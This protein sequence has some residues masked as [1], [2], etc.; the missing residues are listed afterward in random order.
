MIVPGLCS[1]TLRQCSPKEIIEVCRA[2]GLQ[3]VE[4]GGDIHVPHGDVRRAREV[5][6]LCADVGLWIPS[7]GSYYRMDPDGGGLDFCHVLETAVALGAK[8]IRV[9]AGGRP[10]ADMDESYRLCLVDECR[11]IAGLAADADCEI[12]LEYHRNTAMDGNRE[13]L[14]FIRQVGHPAVRSYW[15]PREGCSVV[16]R[17]E[18]LGMIL[19]D[20]CH[21]HVFQ[22]TGQPVVRLSLHDGAIEWTEYLRRV[23]GKPGRVAALLEFVE[24]DLPANVVREAKHLVSLINNAAAPCS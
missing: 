19:P 13:A 12:G 6:G 21:L 11:R 14:E 20:L 24:G 4:W 16:E 7:Y 1:I 2:G 18:G 9:W 8:T 22:W 17:I 23:A 10:S 3:A 5:A 15:Q